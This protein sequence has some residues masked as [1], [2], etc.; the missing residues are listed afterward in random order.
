MKPQYVFG[1]SRFYNIL[2]SAIYNNYLWGVSKAV[3]WIIFQ[4][5]E[6]DDVIRVVCAS[7]DTFAFFT[8]TILRQ[9]SPFSSIISEPVTCS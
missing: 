1:Q 3:R 5:F 6:I 2:T 4:W 8:K 7:S 9:S